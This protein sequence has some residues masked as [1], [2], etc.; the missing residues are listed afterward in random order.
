MDRQIQCSEHGFNIS[1]GY[2]FLNRDRELELV[3]SVWPSDVLEMVGLESN[4]IEF[5]RN[6]GESGRVG[7]AS[8]G[9]HRS[10]TG[11][12]IHE[13]EDTTG[14]GR[15]RAAETKGTA[16]RAWAAT[17]APSKAERCQKR[18]RKQRSLGAPGTGG[19]ARAAAFVLRRVGPRRWTGL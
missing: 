18:K 2:R 8:R 12:S 14:L 4:L 6:E 11:R 19:P 7:L 13:P 10:Q 15:A 1:D 9:A 17:S 5:R 16:A 3:Q